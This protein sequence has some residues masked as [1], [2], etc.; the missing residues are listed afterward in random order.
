MMNTGISKMASLSAEL[1]REEHSDSPIISIELPNEGNLRSRTVV[2]R[3]RARPT[4]KYPSWK[5]GRMI[6]W[7]SC[8]ELNAC[9]LLDANPRKKRC[10]YVEKSLSF[11]QSLRSA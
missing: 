3:S 11:V 7:E 1:Y 10:R 9:R 5:M 6:Q 4:G 2:S 8:N